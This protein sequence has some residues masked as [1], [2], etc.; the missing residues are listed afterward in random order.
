MCK[1][2]LI[3]CI[4]LHRRFQIISQDDVVKEIKCKTKSSAFITSDRYLSA[5]E[6]D[7]R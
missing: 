1:N 5:N 4:T 6:N 3:N 2:N 7:C